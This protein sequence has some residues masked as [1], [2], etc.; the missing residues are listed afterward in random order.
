MVGITSVATAFVFYS[1][2]KIDPTVVVPAV[3]GVFI[4]GQLGARLTR[5]FKARRLAWIFAIILGYLG[6]SLILRAFNVTLPG[7]Q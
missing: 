1:Q 2:E 4:G 6:I 7:Q 5:R 3:I